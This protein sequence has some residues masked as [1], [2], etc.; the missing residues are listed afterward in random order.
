MARLATVHDPCSVASGRP[1]SLVDMGM[2]KRVTVGDDG[3]VDI[4]LRLTSPA[5]YLMPYLESESTRAVSEISGVHRVTVH[6]DEGLDWSPR[7]MSDAARAGRS[8]PIVSTTGP[9]EERR[10][11]SATSLGCRG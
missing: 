11:G 1:L 6:P 8:L 10:T 4:Y 9:A 3:T 7:L 5:C 2:V